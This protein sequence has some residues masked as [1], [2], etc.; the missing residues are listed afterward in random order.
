MTLTL[1]M[2][3][4]WLTEILTQT[5]N[6]DEQFCIQKPIISSMSTCIPC[7]N[8]FQRKHSLRSSVLTYLSTTTYN[9]LA[10]KI[11]V[12]QIVLNPQV[13]LTL[14]M[15][16]VGNTGSLSYIQVRVIATKF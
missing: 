5:N 4:R 3:M 2:Y 1:D 16:T 14:Q 11:H 13:L 8:S 15:T 6:K 7:L 9:L 10:A 12:D